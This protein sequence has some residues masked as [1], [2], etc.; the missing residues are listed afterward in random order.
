MQQALTLSDVVISRRTLL[1]DALLVVVSSM[2]VAL[3]AQ[4]RIDLPF[5]PVPITGQTF[6]VLLAGAVLGASRG[7]LS[8]ALYLAEGAMGLPVF[9]GGAAGVHYLVGPTGGYLVGFVL[10]AGAVGWLAERGWDRRLG[11][12][13]LAM[14]VGNM[15]IYLVGL[16]WL[17][18]FVGSQAA[19]VKG[20]LPFIPGDILKLLLAA[21]ALPSAWRLVGEGRSTWPGR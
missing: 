1:R 7:A 3:S 4:I 10:A 17:A 11:T 9:A 8:L 5:T 14:L 6:G 20:L 2:L 12:A 18:R 19:V 15:I 16:P 21:S 13:I